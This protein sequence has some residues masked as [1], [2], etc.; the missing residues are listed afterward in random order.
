MP[1]IDMGNGKKF[2][3]EY[4][5]VDQADHLSNLATSIASRE[6]E[7]YQYQVNINNFEAMLQDMATLP[8]E[9]PQ[10]LMQY[11]SSTPDELVGI[12]SAEDFDLFMNL[13]FREN[14]RR[15]IATEKTEQKKSMM[16][17]GSLKKQ[18]QDPTEIRRLIAQ[19]KATPRI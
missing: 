16:V 18:V 9:W 11:R 1:Q 15:R 2:D 12:L 13:S 7:V 6:Q 10:R 8:A 14:I 5:G 19:Q 17:L 4:G 3:S